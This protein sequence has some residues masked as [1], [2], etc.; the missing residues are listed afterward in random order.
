MTRRQFTIALAASGTRAFAQSPAKLPPVRAITRGPKFH[1]FG[2]YDKLQFDPSNRYVLGM[3][4]S[5]EH[6][7]PTID[8]SVRLGMVDLQDGDRWTDL[9]VSRSWSWHQGCMLQWLP[10]SKDEVIYNDREQ[11]QF[12]SHILNVRTGR[13]RTLPMPVYA[14]SPD[15]RFAVVNDLRRSYHLRPETGYA[16]V[17][18][19][20]RDVLAPKDSGIWLMDLRTGKHD[21]ILSIADVAA[22]A[23]QEPY[24]EGAKHYFD[25]LLFA[26]DGKRF[27]FFQ[28]WKGAAE[29]RSFR[30][31]MFSANRDGSDV[32]VLDK[33]GKTSH[34]IWRDPKH[35]LVW[36]YHP[37]HGD[38]YYMI[39]DPP[40]KV[41]AVAPA[42]LTEN[43][44]ATYLPGKRWFVTD[45]YPDKERRQHVY[46][47][48][49]RTERRVALGSF[50][51]PPAYTGY[52]RCD[53]TPRISPDGTK[54]IVD[55]PHGGDGR[56]MYLIDI[57]GLTNV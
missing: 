25:H 4:G 52:W 50:L 31:R 32:R 41:E 11:G 47:F 16:G 48:D 21:L 43:G 45:T 30:T 5:F 44:H 13:K 34:Y 12:V 36:M 10:G 8:D 46:L 57:G 2:Y 42:V 39:E 6:R 54:V 27:A 49:T 14:V 9:G 19:P 37:S 15:A 17:P 18:D 38:R 51:S 1:W 29:G 40:G 23:P 35:I 55:S 20:N 22:I 33:Y 7:L 53:T 24:S 56:Q 3:E 28:R 26:P